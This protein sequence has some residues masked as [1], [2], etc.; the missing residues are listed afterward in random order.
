MS[1]NNI[2]LRFRNWSTIESLA[3]AMVVIAEVALFAMMAIMTAHVIG[4]KFGEPI[5]GA[6]EA[7]EQLIIIVFSFPLAAVGLRK[8]HIVFEL[9]VNL[10]PPAFRVRLEVVTH[11][12]LILLFG[13]LSWKGWEKGWQSLLTQEY[14]QAVIDFPVWPF[15][16]ALALGFSVFTG[17]LLVS[18][19]RLIRE[20]MGGTKKSAP[21]RE[22]S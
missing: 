2:W 6:F 8:G 5:P 4:R 12:F 14:R 20:L 3:G 21:L 10:F 16:I 7:S 15:R 13:L 9:I 18:W 19:F 22:L 17:Q 1:S 11:V